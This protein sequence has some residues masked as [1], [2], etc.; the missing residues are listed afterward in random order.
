MRI[1]KGDKIVLKPV[2]QLLTEGWEPI[3]WGWIKYKT[4][5]IVL[6]YEEISYYKGVE[7]IL[8]EHRV[9]T[10][11]LDDGG[12]EGIH[13]AETNYHIAREA[14]GVVLPAQVA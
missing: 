14:I 2:S 7:D 9:L 10:V 1:N 4:P 3:V 11:T 13:C 8:G 5:N 6:A 12:R